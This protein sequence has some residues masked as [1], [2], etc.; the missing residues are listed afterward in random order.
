MNNLPN[1]SNRAVGRLLAVLP[2]LALLT[3]VQAHS[4]SG[5][6]SATRVVSK[7]SASL[8]SKK[9]MEQIFDQVWKLVDEK[10]Y[11]PKFHGVDWG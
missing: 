11:D 5:T 3:I 9:D 10:Y 8:L 6:S 7:D 2:V 1:L 4:P